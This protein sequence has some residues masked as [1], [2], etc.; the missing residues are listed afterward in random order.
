V[1]KEEPKLPVKGEREGDGKKPWEK[2]EPGAVGEEETKIEV[3]NGSV[4]QKKS[5][6]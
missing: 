4:S 5:V 6:E 2:I 3:G 1:V